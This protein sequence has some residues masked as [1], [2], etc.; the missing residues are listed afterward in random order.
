MHIIAVDASSVHVCWQ[1][2]SNSQYTLPT[3]SS[4]QKSASSKSQLHSKQSSKGISQRILWRLVA[5]SN[6]MYH[7]TMLGCLKKERRRWTILTFDH[8]RFTTLKQ[9]Q[10]VITTADW[11]RLYK[12]YLYMQTFI[13]LQWYCH[14]NANTLIGATMVPSLK[15]LPR[16]VK[17]Y[18]K[19]TTELQG[20]I[21]T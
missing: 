21:T 9:L 4:L 12:L 10:I 11:G 8:F 7:V 16:K 1:M 19:W 2:A 15:S 18:W 5:I 14:E 17:S 13:P 20:L 6:T 3:Q